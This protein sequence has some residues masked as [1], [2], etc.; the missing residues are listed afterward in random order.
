VPAV[1]LARVGEFLESPRWPSDLERAI[2]TYR[3]TVAAYQQCGLFEQARQLGYRLQRLKMRRAADLG[4]PR[5]QTG[6]PI[7]RPPDMALS[8]F[9]ARSN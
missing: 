8:R 1:A 5:G 4:L 6:G 2:R 3:R 7:A 9:M